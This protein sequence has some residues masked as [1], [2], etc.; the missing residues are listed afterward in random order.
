MMTYAMGSGIVAG[1]AVLSH[2]EV[3][4]VRLKW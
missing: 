1:T 2:G 4:G 3:E